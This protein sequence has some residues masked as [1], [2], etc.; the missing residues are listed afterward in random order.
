MTASNKQNSLLRI[1]NRFGIRSL[2]R[3]IGVSST[4]PFITSSE[5][6]LQI[7]QIIAFHHHDTVVYLNIIFVSNFNERTN[8]KDAIQSPENSHNCMFVK[9]SFTISS[10]HWT[11][12]WN[13]TNLWT[14]NNNT[15]CT[16]LH[17]NSVYLNSHSHISMETTTKF[18]VTSNDMLWLCLEMSV[19]SSGYC[20]WWHRY[21]LLSYNFVDLV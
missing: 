16:V 17:C 20:S 1:R 14:N 10:M 13:L 5:E 15:F 6:I 18:Q 12:W 11:F 21:K 9:Q 3:K 2:S 8:T 7:L 4:P 19:W